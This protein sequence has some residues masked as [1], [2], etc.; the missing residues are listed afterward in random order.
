MP[1]CEKKEKRNLVYATDLQHA[2][3]RVPVELTRADR[4]LAGPHQ[5]IEVG[6]MGEEL[7]LDVREMRPIGLQNV[8]RLDL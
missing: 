4:A 2:V 7:E 1:P 5:L 3:R 8:R 6:H